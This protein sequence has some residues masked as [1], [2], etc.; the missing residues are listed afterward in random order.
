MRHCNSRQ[1]IWLGNGIFIIWS[2]LYPYASAL[3]AQPITPS[4]NLWP[5]K[6][7]KIEGQPLQTPQA[8]W[9]KQKDVLKDA[10]KTVMGPPSSKPLTPPK[11]TLLEEVDAGSYIRRLIE[12]E[13]DPGTVTPAFLCIPK[14]A[15]MKGAQLPAALCLHPTDDRVGHRVARVGRSPRTRVCA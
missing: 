7:A 11:F 1:K 15:L 2:L 14:R 12:Y 4:R 8:L 5:A 10:M 3:I 9:E 13:T 6:A